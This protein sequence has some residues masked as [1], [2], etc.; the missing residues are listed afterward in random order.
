M[1]TTAAPAVQWIEPPGKQPVAT[2]VD[3]YSYVITTRMPSSLKARIDERL[4]KEKQRDLDFSMNTLVVTAIV[5][6]LDR[7]DRA[8]EIAARGGN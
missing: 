4:R 1:S 7:L 8:E 5:E 6:L 2:A 3:R